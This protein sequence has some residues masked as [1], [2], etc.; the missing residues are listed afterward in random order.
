MKNNSVKYFKFRPAFT[1]IE[2]LVVI[3]IIAILAALLLP[4]LKSAKEKAQRTYCL[5]NEKQLGLAL[6]MYL[7]DCQDYLPWPNWGNDTDPS[8]PAGWLYHPDPNTSAQ[9]PNKLTDVATW[10]AGRSDNLATGT[11][12]QYLKNADVYIC[13]V[14]AVNVV[15]T[16]KPPFNW[17]SYAN[18]LSSYCMDGAGC[19]FPKDSPANRYQYRTA[20][21][22]QVWS[23]LCIIN[24]EP[25][26]TSGN[27]NGYNDGANYPDQ[28]EGVAKTLHTKGAN[29]LS[30]GGNATMW[31]FQD[32]LDEMN[33]PI[34]ND[35]VHGKG[36]LWWSPQRP[37]GHGIE[38]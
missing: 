9:G 16:A 30:V 3:A 31:S 17:I 18:K 25:S 26:G 12:W 2:L 8:C 36:L 35:N 22:S 24:W 33:H 29:V 37:D 28:N 7:T 21:A 32:F 23:P 4:A 13:P 10:N 19:F 15:G 27:N 6:N 38:E 20:K 34:Q 1:L 11:Y 14:F 5:N